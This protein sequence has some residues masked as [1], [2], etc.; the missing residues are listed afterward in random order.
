[1]EKQSEN[2]LMVLGQQ[3]PVFVVSSHRKQF[4]WINRMPCIRSPKRGPLFSD[5]RVRVCPLLHTVM[6]SPLCPMDAP[7]RLPRGARRLTTWLLVVVSLLFLQVR[8][9]PARALLTVE[10][11]LQWQ[12][13]IIVL[14]IQD[15]LKC[16]MR[17][18]TKHSRPTYAYNYNKI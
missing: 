7:S 4:F 5:V 14:H 1:M 18:G 12:Q 9:V 2:L 3:N 17:Q 6:I 13:L 8:G 15:N 11:N 10:A 16:H